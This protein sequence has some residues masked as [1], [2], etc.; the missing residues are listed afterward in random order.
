MG[1]VLS[2]LHCPF[3]P[4][5]APVYFL[6]YQILSESEKFACELA[7]DQSLSRKHC[8]LAAV[9][10]WCLGHQTRRTPLQSEHWVRTWCCHQPPTKKQ[11]GRTRVPPWKTGVQKIYLE[12][13]P[14]ARH[15]S[16]VEGNSSQIN[17]LEKSSDFAEKQT[18]ENTWTTG[19][20]QP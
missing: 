7:D 5:S 1:N 20:P 14:L 4:S 10:P 11:N 8:G 17:L 16:A 3:Q 6:M 19:L 18:G 2:Q 12:D 15:I 9:T 13:E